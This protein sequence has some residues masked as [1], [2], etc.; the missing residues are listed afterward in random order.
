VDALL[1]M[2]QRAPS[3]L[4]GQPYLWEAAQKSA[5][6]SSTMGSR[7]LPMHLFTNGSLREVHLCTRAI[8]FCR[9]CVKISSAKSLLTSHS[10]II[11][12]T[13]ASSI[14]CNFALNSFKTHTR[15][16]PPPRNSLVNSRQEIQL[17]ATALGC[18]IAGTHPLP[19]SVFTSC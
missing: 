6:S 18:R 3:R 14:V 19:K 17:Q 7:V 1:Q 11:S 4:A 10:S 9:N 12:S 8:V 15:V 16:T 13:A 2:L 5:I